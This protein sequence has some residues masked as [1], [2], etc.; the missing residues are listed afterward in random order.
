MYI[1]CMI[2]LKKEISKLNGNAPVNV[3]DLRIMESYVHKGYFPATKFCP[4]QEPNDEPIPGSRRL[5]LRINNG[6][7]V[8]VFADGKFIHGAWVKNTELVDFRIDSD[9][10]VRNYGRDSEI[11]EYPA[12]GID[13]RHADGAGI[14]DIVNGITNVNGLADSERMALEA[15]LYNYQPIPQDTVIRS[16]L[17]PFESFQFSLA[18]HGGTVSLG[19]VIE[20][21]RDTRRQS[22]RD[23]EKALA[24]KTPYGIEQR[25]QANENEKLN[26]QVKRA[27]TKKLV[28]ETYDDMLLNWQ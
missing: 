8:F 6:H 14:I 21:S 10:V 26:A 7:N 28:A 22:R 1:Y 12:Q 17:L 20:Q 11:L 16:K 3:A 27:T 4:Q 23:L 2:N 24:E 5:A 15:Q 25:R 18:E 19:R 13:L 9:C